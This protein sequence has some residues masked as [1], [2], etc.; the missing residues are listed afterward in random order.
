[1]FYK[2]FIFK[3]LILLLAKCQLFIGLMCTFINFL[4]E[5]WT[6]VL[7]LFQSISE[8]PFVIKIETQVV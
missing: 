7:T 5:S 3:F 4:Y 6:G 8:I 2:L 1:M